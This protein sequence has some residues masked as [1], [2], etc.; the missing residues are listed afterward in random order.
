M[1]GG[2][3]CAA[4][5]SWASIAGYLNS[6]HPDSM[7]AAMQALAVPFDDVIT[8]FNSKVSVFRTDGKGRQLKE[9]SHLMK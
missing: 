6:D 2:L 5:L 7:E 9:S 8:W 1:V 4:C 3:A